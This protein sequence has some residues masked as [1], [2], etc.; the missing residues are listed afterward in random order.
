MKDIWLSRISEQDV[1][2][3]IKNIYLPTKE[4]KY[5]AY[6]IEQFYINFYEDK[7][8]VNISWD[9]YTNMSITLYPFDLYSSESDEFEENEVNLEW[10]TFLNNKSA[11]IK[12]NGKTYLEDMLESLSKE[13]EKNKNDIIQIA[14]EEAQQEYDNYINSVK[15]V[16][17]QVLSTR[18]PEMQ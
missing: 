4:S 2:Y 8:E 18:E 9:F 14:I 3:F 15:N 5:S 10:V 17:S 6:D 1:E 12:I 11:G 13:A 7:I 16:I